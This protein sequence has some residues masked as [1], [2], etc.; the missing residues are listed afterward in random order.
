MHVQSGTALVVTA[1]VASLLL[2]L[3]RGERVFAII[4]VIA[5][6]IMALIA[7]DVITFSMKPVRVDVTLPALLV[8]AG[9]AC[10]SRLSTKGQVT[11][12]TTLVLVGLL[13]LLSAVD[14][15]R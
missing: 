15:L 5:S 8:I 3:G 2:L 11:A 7:F 13:Q 14:V 6:G 4:A 9:A 10:W 1:L 12:A